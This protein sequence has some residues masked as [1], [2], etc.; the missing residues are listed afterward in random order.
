MNPI[1]PSRTAKPVTQQPKFETQ[2]APQV[3]RAIVHHIKTAALKSGV[4]FRYMMATAAS[5]SGFNSR[6]KAVGSSATG[7]YQFT[8]TSWLE[9]VKRHGARH[10]LAKEAAAIN[11]R[12]K[13]PD[14]KIRL[15]ILSLRTD[16]KL[17]AAM[18][19]EFSS[20]NKLALESR[21]GREISGSE[22]YLAH[23]LGSEGATKFIKSVEKNTQQPAAELFPAAAAANPSVFYD[24]KSGDAKTVGEIYQK[25]SQSIN[26]KIAEF[27][28]SQPSIASHSLPM[29]TTQLASQ[30][31][32][33]K[34]LDE[35]LAKG[36]PMTILLRLWFS[37]DEEHQSTK[38]I[39]NQTRL[40]SLLTSPLP[41]ANELNQ[42]SLAKAKLAYGG[43]R[44]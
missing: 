10:G 11:D 21:L 16:A 1:V 43:I 22:L 31:P 7:L 24:K 2:I 23:F 12:G 38:S 5:E 30:S 27:T 19:A 18:A 42:T 13:V 4:D 33:F 44:I 26:Q 37:Q 17:S 20:D 39:D 32:I 3:N 36:D 40:H 41:T 25:F 35:E 9:T 8:E 28:E 34:E 6:A 14:A 29:V 15:E